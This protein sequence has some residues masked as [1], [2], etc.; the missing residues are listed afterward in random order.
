MKFNKISFKRNA[1]NQKSYSDSF[2][3][4]IVTVNLPSASLHTNKKNSSTSSVVKDTKPIKTVA[5]TTLASGKSLGDDSIK[6]QLE[7]GRAS[8]TTQN[9][10]D[11]FSTVHENLNETKTNYETSVSESSSSTSLSTN[12]ATSAAT[13]ANDLEIKVKQLKDELIKKK[14][15][16]EKLRQTLKLKEKSKLREKE[17]F[18]RKKINSYDSLI[19]KIKVALEKEQE[20]PAAV[21][22]NTQLE[23]SNKSPTKSKP[24]VESKRPKSRSETLEIKTESIKDD[25]DA[26]NDEDDVDATS[27]SSTSQSLTIEIKNFNVP[28]AAVKPE[29]SDP[30]KSKDSKELDDVSSSSSSS[31]SQS[32]SRTNSSIKPKTSK[33]AEDEPKQQKQQRHASTTSENKYDDDDFVTTDI[34]N[35]SSASKSLS[36]SSSTSLTKSSAKKKIISS[37]KPNKDLDLKVSVFA[38]TFRKKIYTT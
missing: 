15:E 19:D 21:A 10:Y 8:T 5:T 32:S 13:T 1:P 38:D 31:S 33:S 36:S 23:K 37:L 2:E 7:A 35:K 28:Q 29:M 12:T 20:E 27:T 17:E 6:T 26:V 18:L 34:P 4:S 11:D 24:S 25:L 9:K 14:N 22:N 30:K 3:S 16:A